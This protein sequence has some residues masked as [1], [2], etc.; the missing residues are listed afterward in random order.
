M[1]RWQIR[2]RKS[3]LELREVSMGNHMQRVSFRR[4]GEE[5]GCGQC[6]VREGPDQ[7]GV[8]GFMSE[9]DRVFTHHQDRFL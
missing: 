3:N 1:L 5:V 6:E 4:N 9:I 8:Y 2:T 7:E